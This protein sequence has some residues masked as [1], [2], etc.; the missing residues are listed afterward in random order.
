MGLDAN[1]MCNCYRGGLQVPPELQG[2]IVFDDEGYLSLKPSCDNDDTLQDVFYA[3]TQ[4][5]CPHE[6]MRMAQER[7]ANWTGVREFKGILKELGPWK[8]WTLLREI[9]KVN[10]GTTHPRKAK[11]M[12]KEL[13][14]FQALKDLGRKFVLLDEETDNEICAWSGSGADP[15]VF[16]GKEDLVLALDKTGFVIFRS[17]RAIF[18]SQEFTQELLEPQKTENW[19]YGRVKFIDQASGE[20]VECFLAVA[21]EEIPWPNGSWENEKGQVRLRY[22]S[23]FRTEWRKRTPDDYRALTTSLRTV[24]QA[25]VDSGNP[26]RWA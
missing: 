25:S 20:T 11:K 8:F 21:G 6:D 13:E 3:W 5:A 16:S 23:R 9:P 22:P 19:E 1:V 17:N 7:I 26:I 12:L 18:R 15:F 2:L 14:N 10:G 24:C 4:N